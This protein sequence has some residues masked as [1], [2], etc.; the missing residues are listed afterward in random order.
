MDLAHTGAE[1]DR[2][3]QQARIDLMIPVIKGWLTEV[4]Q[5]LTSLGLQVHGGMG[6]V[7]ETGAAQYMRDVRIGSIY[8]GTT[9]IQ[10]ADLVTRKVGRDGGAAMTAVRPAPG[11]SSSSSSSS[12]KFGTENWAVL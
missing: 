2:R 8:E 4:A 6:Y 5:E 11:T 12:S 10:A 1:A 3:A 7:E 9:G